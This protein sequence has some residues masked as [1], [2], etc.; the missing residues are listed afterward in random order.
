MKIKVKFTIYKKEKHP[1]EDRDI[2][3][4]NDF[5]GTLIGIGFDCGEKGSWSTGIVVTPDGRLNNV[6][7]ER[8][9]LLEPFKADE[10]N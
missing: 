10:W 5:E 3:V 8:L 9:S 1:T 6:P 2:L 7:I 4:R